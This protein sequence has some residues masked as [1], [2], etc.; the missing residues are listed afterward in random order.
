[1]AISLCAFAGDSGTPAATMT[2]KRVYRQGAK[3]AKAKLTKDRVPNE[4]GFVVLLVWLR[5]S[6]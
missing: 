4:E 6:E 1:M 2:A 3:F 5:R